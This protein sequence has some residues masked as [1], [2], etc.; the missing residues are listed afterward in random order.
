MGSDLHSG[1]RG[2]LRKA[3]LESTRPLCEHEL[4][5]LLLFC[6]LP[7]VNTNELAHLLIRRFGSL[8][9]VLE[10]PADQIAEV[11]GISTASAQFLRFF[12]DM[13]RD[14]MESVRGSSDVSGSREIKEWIR[15]CLEEGTG[16]LCVIV[17]ADSSLRPLSRITFSESRAI[18]SPEGLRRIAERVFRD[19]CERIIIGISHTGGQILP[20]A[21]DF[22]LAAEVSGAL[23]PMGIRLADC[24]IFCGETAFSMRET[25][26]FSF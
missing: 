22:R 2:R 26:A 16:E 1:H 19:G 13:R 8:A 21:D 17:T 5:E 15:G 10:A 24:I 18:G 14:Y 7:R 20:E 11:K 9:A 6:V 4:L 3:F 25:G 23:A 12:G